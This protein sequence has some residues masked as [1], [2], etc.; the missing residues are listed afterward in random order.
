M[1]ETYCWKHAIRS[2]QTWHKQTGINRPLPLSKK[3]YRLWRQYGSLHPDQQAKWLYFWGDWEERGEIVLS[4]GGIP[5]DQ[6]Q[7]N[8]GLTL[9]TPDFSH[10][11][12]R[13]KLSGPLS[14]LS[15]VPLKP[16][17]KQSLDSDLF[18]EYRELVLSQAGGST[19]TR[20]HR[21]TE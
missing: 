11:S 8:C 6:S 18:S 16:L 21:I 5:Y 4:C 17:W 12:P 3:D 1:L 20:L 7:I 10:N 15:W 19:H 14:A 13:D 9:L 2:C